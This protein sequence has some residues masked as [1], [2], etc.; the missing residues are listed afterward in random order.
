MAVLLPVA[1]M[2][3]SPPAPESAEPSRVPPRLPVISFEPIQ[4]PPPAFFVP[5]PPLP[6]RETAPQAPA[7]S[8]PAIRKEQQALALLGANFYASISCMRQ[9]I[10]HKDPV[11]TEEDEISQARQR[12]LETVRDMGPVTGVRAAVT[13]LEKH[14]GRARFA[15][16]VI[17]D[18]FPDIAAV[19]AILGKEDLVE[20][21]GVFT[22]RDFADTGGPADRQITWYHYGWLAFATSD[23]K[24][25]GVRAD[26]RKFT[27]APTPRSA[28][29]GK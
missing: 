7:S 15:V 20:Q 29:A 13:M 6:G 21:K 27:A 9:Y 19:Q 14:R 22:G 11:P 4:P 17:G 1:V 5:P 24:V 8:D 2:P 10:L 25:L 23:G 28:A 18:G 3:D 16:T 12:A 26:C